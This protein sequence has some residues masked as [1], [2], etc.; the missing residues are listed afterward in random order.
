MKSLSVKKGS[1][2][3]EVHVPPSKSYANRALILAALSQKKLTLKNLPDAKDVIFLI[4]SLEDL[5]LQMEKTDSSLTIINSYPACETHGSRLDVGEGGTTARFLSALLLLGKKEYTLVLGERLKDRPWEEFLKL[6][7]SLGGKVSLEG[8]ELK[9]QGPVKLPE[10]LEVDCQETTQFATAFQLLSLTYKVKVIP[11]NLKTS[12]SYWLMTDKMIKE[13]QSLDSY[14]IPL[15][16]SSASYPLAFGA[17][18]Q[19]I[20]FPHLHWDEYQADAKFFHILKDFGALTESSSGIEVSP[21]IKARNLSI[22]VSD[23]LDL[24]P[25]LAYFL[26]HIKGEHVLKG[27]Q[28]LIHKESDRLQEILKILAIFDKEALYQNDCIKIQG[29][30]EQVPEEKNL[31]LPDDHRMVMVGTLFLLQHAG[32][33]LSPCEAVEKSYPDFFSLLSEG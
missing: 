12:Q 10:V 31:L 18:N 15:D 13:F 23:C 14:S 26:S 29:S 30:T 11:Q 33:T 6:A 22:D 3:S 25:T 20:S 16:W 7:R 17:L 19:K 32:G 9:I 24:A 27:V 4:K 1:L 28:N 2:V 5:G 8:R 21:V